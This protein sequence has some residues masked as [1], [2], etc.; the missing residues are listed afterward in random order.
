[1]ACHEGRQTSRRSARSVISVPKLTRWGF[2]HRT[3][4]LNSNSSCDGFLMTG[5]AR[6][7]KMCRMSKA[8]RL[9]LLSAVPI[10]VTHMLTAQV[11]CPVMLL[12]GDAGKDTITLSFMNKG[13]F[14]ISRLSLSCSPSSIRATRDSTCHTENA[15]FFPGTEYS[16]NF[17]YPD[18]SKYRVVISVKEA[19]L[20]SGA[21]WDT[22][23]TDSCR[24]LRISRRK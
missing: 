18:A 15:V 6:R 13:K 5:S 14:P 20:S 8:S 16:I 11:P 17:S 2:G 19:I 4:K 21:R 22:H 23:S 12:S 9:R 1:M 7:C 24:R 10:L 3:P